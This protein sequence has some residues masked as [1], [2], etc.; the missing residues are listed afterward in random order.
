MTSHAYDV[1]PR[2]KY[3][4]IEQKRELHKSVLSA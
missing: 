4:A 3:E 1:V 2:A